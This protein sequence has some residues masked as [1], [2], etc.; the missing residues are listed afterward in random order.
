ML[1]NRKK[2][3]NEFYK[4]I[5]FFY[6]NRIY[7]DKRD[8]LSEHLNSHF[9]NVSPKLE[10]QINDYIVTLIPFNVTQDQLV[11]VSCFVLSM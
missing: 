5:L 7:T 3:F 8:I 4:S 11:I 6:N 9:I 2:E 1:I 10:A